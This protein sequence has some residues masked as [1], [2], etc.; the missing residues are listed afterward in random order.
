MDGVSEA[1]RKYLDLHMPGVL[2]EFLQEYPVVAER[3]LCLGTRSCKSRLK[4]CSGVDRAHSFATSAPCGLQDH[5]VSDTVRNRTAFCLVVYRFNCA[6]KGRYAESVRNPPAGG[7]T[8][9]LSHGIRRGTDK[10]DPGTLHRFRELRIF[11]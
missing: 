10:A 5:R 8:P 3:R 2:Q 1:V 4:F 11:R 6:C 7:F 9:E